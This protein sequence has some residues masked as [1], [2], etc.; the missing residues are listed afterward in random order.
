[1][2]IVLCWDGLRPDF[3]CSELTPNLCR[4]IDDGVNFTNHHAVFPTETRVNASSVSTGCY[5]GTHGVVGNSIYISEV[6]KDSPLNT[7][8]HEDLQAISRVQRLLSVPTLPELLRRNKKS[9]AIFSSGSPGSSWVQC[10]PLEGHMVNVRGVVHPEHLLSGLE[11]SYGKFPPE[12]VPAT[13]RNDRVIQMMMD[14][15][16]RRT[17]DVVFG[18]LCDPDLTQHKVGLGADLALQAIR[19]ND[20]RLGALLEVCPDI[21]IMVCSDHGFSSLE[22]PFDYD[23]MFQSAGFDTDKIVWTGN[24]V[25]L[26]D[27]YKT[28]RADVVNFLSTQS[29]IGPIFTQGKGGGMGQVSGTLSFDVIQLNHV[30]TPDVTFSRKWSAQKN[31]FGVPGFVYGAKGIASHGSCSPYDLH[32]VLIAKGPSFKKGESSDCPSGVVDIA[33]TILHLVLGMLPAKMDGRVLYESLKIGEAPHL[34]D[35]R[36]WESK[37]GSRSQ[38]V[39]ISQVNE[40]CYIDKGWV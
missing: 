31:A 23:R 6:K 32:N 21:D 35:S 22:D 38:Y 4:L 10:A 39:Q 9:Y 17:Y 40:T 27:D 14:V 19:E 12:A 16:E 26:R 25:V 5:P 20:T 33:P 34:V 3:V 7:G 15:I 36:I 24:G 2:F 18:W 29:W 37:I 13:S 1:M 8:N 11:A 30:R 28:K